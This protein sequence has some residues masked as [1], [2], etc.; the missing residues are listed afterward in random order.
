MKAFWANKAS[1]N[2]LYQDIPGT[3]TPLAFIHGLGCASSCDYPRVIAEAALAGRRAILVDLLGS[4]FSERPSEF[5]YSM[6]GHARL[7]AELLSSV[8]EGPISIFGHS[9]GGAVAITTAALLGA[10]VEALVLSEPNLEPGGGIFSKAIAEMSEAEFI[11]RGHAATV[12]NARA[13]GNTV[14]AASL[15]V[16]APFAVHREAAS[17]VAGCMPTWRDMLRSLTMPKTVLVGERSLPSPE[18]D[19]LADEGCS[20]EIVPEAGHSM[21]WDNPSGLAHAIRNATK[22]N[23][24]STPLDAARA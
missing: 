23:P 7:V 21:A 5:C 6:E 15:A 16:S 17:L 4:G 22:L 12:G 1:A 2:I 13:A 10:K 9:M 8:C 3:G 19:G 24:R 20:V 11:A 14:W 18:F